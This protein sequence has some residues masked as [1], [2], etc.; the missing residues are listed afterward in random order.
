MKNIKSFKNNIRDTFIIFGFIPLF[1]FIFALIS[2]FKKEN[3]KLEHL[4]LMVVFI[5]ILKIF[6]F[7][8]V[9][10]FARKEIIIYDNFFMI[11]RPFKKRKIEYSEINGIYEKSK[12]KKRNSQKAPY[13]LIKMKDESEVNI[14]INSFKDKQRD[15]FK[16]I[17]KKIKRTR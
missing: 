3:I 6:L 14:F 2:F 11:K 10:V 8:L 13:L 4:L 15:I 12:E 1:L 17:K 7:I 16:T 9:W 5:I